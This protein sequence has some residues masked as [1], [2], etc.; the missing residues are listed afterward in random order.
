MKE[1]C[2]PSGNVHGGTKV[3]KYLFSCF[4]TIVGGD[5]IQALKDKG[6]YL[7]LLEQF[8]SVKNFITS[9]PAK[10]VACKI[11]L[12]LLNEL[13]EKY[14]N[15]NFNALLEASNYSQNMSLANDRLR[16]DKAFI[17]KYISEV[18]SGIMEDIKYVLFQKAQSR[19]ISTFFVV[20]GFSNSKLVKQ[21]LAD[22]FPDVVIIYPP[23]DVELTVVR[24]AVLYGKNP[25]Y[26]KPSSNKAHL[27]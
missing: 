2:K 24:G 7:E 27:R 4:E 20:G 11:P 22:E 13:C 10:K 12:N 16:I 23:D 3:D 26:I 21:K 6:G 9:N 15:K 1:L 25:N 17:E 18:A 19:N 14:N 5:V 8:E